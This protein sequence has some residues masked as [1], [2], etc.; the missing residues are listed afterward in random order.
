[1]K[2]LLVVLALFAGLLMAA[3]ACGGGSSPASGTTSSNGYAPSRLSNGAPVKGAPNQTAGGGITAPNPGG[4]GLTDV[5]PPVQGP[6]VIRQAQLSISVK[7][8]S[9]DSSLA[10]VRALVEVE[11]GYPQRHG[12]AVGCGS[13]ES[14]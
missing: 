6:Q 10:Q 8:G 9:F 7:S 11:Q 1:M 14:T 13:V 5:V 12:I 2:R 4:G 3:A